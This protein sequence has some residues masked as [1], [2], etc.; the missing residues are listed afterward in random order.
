MCQVDI[1]DEN[2]MVEKDCLEIASRRNPS[3]V[4]THLTYCQQALKLKLKHLNDYDSI[5]GRAHN[6]FERLIRWPTSLI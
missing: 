2:F 6:A 3:E 5:C 4:V 1:A